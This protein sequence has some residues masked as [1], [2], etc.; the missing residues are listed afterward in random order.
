VKLALHGQQANALESLLVAVG[1]IMAPG[2]RLLRL[3]VVETGQPE[4]TRV[5]AVEE[6]REAELR[7]LCSRILEAVGGRAGDQDFLAALAILTQQFIQQQS[8]ATQ[9]QPKET[10]R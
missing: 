4:S 5:I 6:D 3:S 8:D 10:E 1:G 2:S 9:V 7:R